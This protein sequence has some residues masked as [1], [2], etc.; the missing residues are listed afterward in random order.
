[1]GHSAGPIWV[2]RPRACRA[3]DDRQKKWG[4]AL[5]P[6]PTAPS[7]GSA[8]VRNLVC[9]CPKALG[10]PALDPGSPAQASLS[11]R[12]LPPKRSPDL[13]PDCASR[14]FACLSMS[15][16]SIENSILE[17]KSLNQF[18][19]QSRP[20]FHGPSWGNHSCVPLC[21]PKFRRTPMSRVAREAITSSGASS[22]LTPKKTRKLFP[23]SAGGDRTFGHLPRPSNCC[24]L[25]E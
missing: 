25:S 10:L 24:Q 12:P 2:V 3:A 5:L 8:G 23:L 11:I 9:F 22:R 6:A 20:M 14:G 19:G 7:E 4:P 15:G 17:P 16:L 1:M 18:P 21:L 13:L